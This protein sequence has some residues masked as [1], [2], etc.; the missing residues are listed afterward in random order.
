MPITTNASIA[1]AKTTLLAN[2]LLRPLFAK[3]I[4]M[5]FLK[6]DTEFLKDTGSYQKG[7]TINIAVTPTPSTTI[8]TA[9]G[10]AI[11]YPKQTL[12]S[13]ALTLESI[14]VTAFSINGGDLASANIDPTSAQVLTT[15]E[16]H[17]SEIEKNLFLTTFN[18]ASIDANRLGANGTVANYK[19]LRTIWT[20]FQN[21]RVSDAQRKIVVLTPEMYSEL[22]NDPL[23]ARTVATNGGS[24]SLS[25]GILDKTLNMEIYSSIN[26]P[27]NLA[28]TNITGAGTEKVGF[29]FTTDSIV[30]AV[31]ELP[32]LGNDRGVRQAIARSDEYNIATRVTESYNAQVVGGDLMYQMETLYGSKIYRPTTVFPILG[33]VA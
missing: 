27:T 2:S 1:Q 24:R 17:G 7:A 25:D 4:L 5:N 19:L 11:T 6:N 22:L 15:A 9:T 29:A 21:A 12:T 8:A 10:G 14:A 33:G 30:A 18:D 3:N 16:S 31:R 13:V 28:L 20:A 26:L 32:L 23:V